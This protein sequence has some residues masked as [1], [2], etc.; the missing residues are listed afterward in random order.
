MLLASAWTRGGDRSPSNWLVDIRSG[1]FRLSTRTFQGR[2]KPGVGLG[3]TIGFSFVDGEIFAR[4]AP[5]R[6]H[7]EVD[8]VLAAFGDGRLR[9]K[10][11]PKDGRKRVQVI[12]V[13]EAEGRDGDIDL[14][15][16]D[17]RPE[18]AFPGTSLQNFIQ[19]ADEWRVERLQGLAILEVATAVQVLIG[20]ENDKIAV[21][22]QIVERELD[23]AL[24]R[25]F[26]RER[27]DI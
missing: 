17:P 1:N 26:R 20:K 8:N 23:E 11:F 24:H 10:V 13:K 21:L 25:L 6:V 14:A 5:Q 22:V 2:P 3:F 12:E 4:S 16:I 18:D 7:H 19:H 27:A 15:R 9:A